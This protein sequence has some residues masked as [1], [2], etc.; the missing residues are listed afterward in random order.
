MKYLMSDGLV[1]Q[2]RSYR[3]IVQEMAG[4]KMRLPRTRASY[5]QRVSDR[6]KDLYGWDVNPRS[7]STF[8]NDLEK[9]GLME[10]V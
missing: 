3:E 7:D 6:V 4:T 9:Y 1:L 10:K 2:G 5:R 8:V